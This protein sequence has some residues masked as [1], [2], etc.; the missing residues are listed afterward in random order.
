MKYQV[1]NFEYTSNLTDIKNKLKTIILECGFKFP[2]QDLNHLLKGKEWGYRFDD[3]EEILVLLQYS[4]KNEQETLI[5]DYFNFDTW[6][7]IE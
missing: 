6:K 2:I 3:P 5:F 1:V 7:N 4:D